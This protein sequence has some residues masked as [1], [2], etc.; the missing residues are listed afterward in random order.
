MDCIENSIVWQATLLCFFYLSNPIA[1]MPVEGVRLA[2]LEESPTGLA[3]W[4]FCEARS[5]NAGPAIERTS[6]GEPWPI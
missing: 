6:P 1:D 2:R 3:G 5:R 4:V